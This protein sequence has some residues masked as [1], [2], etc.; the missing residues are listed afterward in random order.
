[1]RY[2][3]VSDVHGNFEAL[4]A[5][6]RKAEEVGVTGYL[7]LGDTVGY[8]TMPNECVQALRDRDAISIMGNHDVVACG[9]EE[10]TYFNPTAR[11]AIVWA[12]ENLTGENREYLANL[13]DDRVVSEE[14]MIVHG[15]VHNRDEYLLF[16]PDIER[17]FRLLQKDHPAVRVVF[18]GHTHR[19]MVYFRK[20][21]E[22]YWVDDLTTLPLEDGTVYLINPGSVGQPRDGDRRAAFCV[23]DTDNKHVEFYRVNFDID[24]VADAVRQLP[25]GASLGDRLYRGV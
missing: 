17:S 24:K 4:T 6:F 9:R 18:F 14:L 19:R 2:A 10:P 7:N 5:V 21:D 15:S 8:Y 3:V 16:R 1:M 22:L 20:Q 12:R 25:F 11:Q 13:P 23:Y